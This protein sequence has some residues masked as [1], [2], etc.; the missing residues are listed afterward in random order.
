MTLSN[1]G[2][3]AVPHQPA[4]GTANALRVTEPHHTS[5]EGERKMKR[6][7]M[8]RHVCL[9]MAIVGLSMLAA[10]SAPAAKASG[11]GTWS[12]TASMSVPREYHTATRLADGRV[13]VVGGE[14]SS[15]AQLASAELYD[16]TRGTWAPTGPLHIARYKHTATLLRNGTVLVAGGQMF[17]PPLHIYTLASAEIYD[18]HTGIWTPTGSMLTPRYDFS[19]TLLS[20]GRVLVAGGAN[21]TSSWLTSAEI[22]DPHTGRWSPTG[23]LHAGRSQHTSTLLPTGQVLIVGGWEGSASADMETYNPASGAWT[24]VHTLPGQLQGDS[25]TLLANGRVLIAAGETI[26]CNPSI[27]CGPYPL[28]GASLYNPAT[29]GWVATGSLSQARAYHSATL[30]Q[31]GLVLVAGGEYSYPISSTELY[32]PGTSAWTSAGNMS[33][34]R[35]FHTATLL[36]DGRVLVTGGLGDCGPAW[37]NILSSAELYT[38]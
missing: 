19:A 8:T 16:P 37:C 20:D 29:G 10:P 1:A 31:N 22:Y 7:S 5:L 24:V 13:L 9:G 32:N 2:R 35:E 11:A 38:P 14:N 21:N 6:H 27:G 12:I 33:T 25:T 36:Q 23:A 17:V 3:V 30:L 18:P 34:T 15:A 28:A 4:E 26:Y